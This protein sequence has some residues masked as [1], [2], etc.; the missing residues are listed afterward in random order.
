[1]GE[2]VQ[3]KRKKQAASNPKCMLLHDVP[4]SHNSKQMAFINFDK[5][6]TNSSVLLPSTP[7]RRRREKS[8]LVPKDKINFVKDVLCFHASA[9]V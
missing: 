5:R 7:R 3:R 1:M 8:F 9:F 4:E 2:F 6:R